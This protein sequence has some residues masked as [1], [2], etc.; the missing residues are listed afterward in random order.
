MLSN[1]TAPIKYTFTGNATAD[2]STV[3][4]TGTEYIT[5][6]DGQENATLFIQELS[7][8]DPQTMTGRGIHIAYFHTNSTGQLKSLDGMIGVGTDKINA[9]GSSDQTVWEWQS[10]IPYIKELAN[11]P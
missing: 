1:G 11:M 9:D 3:F 5:T 4:L 10:G 2:F 8:F 7:R 6:E